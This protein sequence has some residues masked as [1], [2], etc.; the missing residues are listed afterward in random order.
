MDTRRL[1][2]FLAVVDTGS[3]TAAAD[4][5]GVTQP[6]VSQAV[7]ALERELGGPLFHRARRGVRLTD[8]GEALCVPARSA[9]RDVDAARRAVA[10]VRELVTGRLELACLPTLAAD[11][12][13][14]LLGAFRA[15]HDA[16]T[17]RLLDPEDTADALELVRSGRCELALVAEAPLAR[18]LHVMPIGWQSFRAVL[19]PGTRAPDPL[20][21]AALAGMPMMAPPVGSSSR[22]VLDAVLAT[23]GDVASV[24]VESAQRE[25]LLPL[26]AAGAGAALV[27]AALAESAARLGCVVATLDPPVGRAVSLVRRDAP[28][29]PAAEAFCALAARE[30]QRPVD[31]S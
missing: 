12:L 26:V 3:F 8:A 9:V 23:T 19:P 13:A 7:A 31:P 24:V 27:P 11:P 18:G 10:G 5:L 22:D 1:E 15:R 14:P 28:L 29:T 25:A 2:T 16:V 30:P 17:V 6:A 20:R 21:V 4:E